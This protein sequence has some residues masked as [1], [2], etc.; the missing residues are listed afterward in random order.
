MRRGA[1]SPFWADARAAI[2]TC[3]AAAADQSAGKRKF[4]VSDGAI[5]ATLAKTAD[6]EP[7]G[8][9]PPMVAAR[10][11]RV[12]RTVD[13]PRGV[14]NADGKVCVGADAVASAPNVV[15]ARVTTKA[16]VL[17]HR[18]AIITNEVVPSLGSSSG[19]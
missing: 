17:L 13:A 7:S 3:G 18:P 6:D 10:D 12:A 15:S 5:L 19:R 16:T 8:K 9:P 14:P 1:A 2:T 11:L 4:T